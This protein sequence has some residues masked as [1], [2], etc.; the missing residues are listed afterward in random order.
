MFPIHMSNEQVSRKVSEYHC[1][2][3]LEKRYYKQVIAADL[4]VY[5]HA[6]WDLAV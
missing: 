1:G 5:V 6:R 4:K 2:M 3:R